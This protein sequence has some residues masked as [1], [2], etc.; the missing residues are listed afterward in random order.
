MAKIKYDMDDSGAEEV[1]AFGYPFTD[2]KSTE[3]KEEDVAK[4]AGNRFFI[5]AAAKAEKEEKT[6]ED[7]LKAVH[8]GGG[9]FVIKDGDKVV[10]DG[11]NKADADAFNALSDEDKTAYVAD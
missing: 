6:A 9:H 2:G 11:L 4:F 10:K 5:A 8:N 1:V 7:G 3:V